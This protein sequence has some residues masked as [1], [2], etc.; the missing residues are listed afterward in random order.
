MVMS[1]SE[2]SLVSDFWRITAEFLTIS[3]RLTFSP[4][5]LSYC[6]YPELGRV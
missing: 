2:N 4:G 5:S 3:F 1:T 6:V